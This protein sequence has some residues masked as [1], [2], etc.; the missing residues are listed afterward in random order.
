[1]RKFLLAAFAG[2]LCFSSCNNTA[3]VAGE[4][5]DNSMAQK[6][7]EA[8]RAVGKA[9]ETGDVSALDTLIADDFLDHTDRG[10]V[11]GRDSLKAM[12]KMVHDTMKDMKSETVK[13]LADNEYVFSWMRFTGTSNGSMGMP[14]GPYDMKS[15]EVARFKDGKIVEHWTFMDMQDV[16]KMMGQMPGADKNA[17]NMNDSTKMK[18]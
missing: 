14:A 1:M 5:K 4:N 18:K 16:M 13:D 2:L 11:R 17:M 8:S 3:T 6:N 10:D 9:F 7:M 12:V 15:I